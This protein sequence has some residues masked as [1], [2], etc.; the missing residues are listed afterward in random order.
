LFACG[1][2]VS[3]VTTRSWWYSGLRQASI[4]VAAGL[5]T[6]FLGTLVGSGIG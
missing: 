1:A 2:A 6:Y 5:L 3:R 4:G